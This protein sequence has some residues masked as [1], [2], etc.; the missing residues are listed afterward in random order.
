MGRMGAKG[1]GSSTA[2]ARDSMMK[3]YSRSYVAAVTLVLLAIGWSVLVSHTAHSPSG[4][5]KNT[6]ARPSPT[7][8]SQRPRQATKSQPTPPPVMT[9]TSAKAAAND[10]GA[11]P[12]DV[13]R[14][15][16]HLGPV[17]TTV[18]DARGA[19]VTNLKIEDFELIVDGKQQAISDIYR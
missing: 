17:P 16:S 12:D 15:S 11:S 19:A 7:P 5:Q 1:D 9:Q 6:T 8:G 2:D 3:R 14:V 18:V 10:N 13:V 4:R